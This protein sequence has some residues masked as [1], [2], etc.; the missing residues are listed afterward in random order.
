MRSLHTRCKDQ[1]LGTN[2]TVVKYLGTYPKGWGDVRPT[3]QWQERLFRAETVD[4]D[5]PAGTGG[6]HMIVNV[7]RPIQRTPVRNW[8][9]CALDGSTLQQ[10]DVHPTTLVE[11]DNTPGGRTGGSVSKHG[12]RVFDIE[13]R[14]IDVRVGETTTP[15]YDP[16][17]RWIFY[18]EMTRDEVLLLKVF[19]SRRDGRVRCGAH[20]AFKDPHG[21]PE[22][23]RESIEVRCLVILAKDEA[24]ATA[25]AVDADANATP[26][27]SRL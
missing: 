4:H 12:S 15:L 2:E 20:C 8:G 14:P 11:F 5:S 25:T 1:I 19:D 27:R 18:P 22:A 3:R 26:Q 16:A 7:W 21:D 6:E 9:L 13:G 10:G 24:T 17:H 23:Y